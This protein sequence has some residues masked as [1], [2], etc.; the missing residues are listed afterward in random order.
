MCSVSVLQTIRNQFIIL[1]TEIPCRPNC[2]R[3]RSLSTSIS[4][5][6]CNMSTQAL[7]TIPDWEHISGLPADSALEPEGAAAPR[8]SAGPGNEW[9]G[10][11]T[12]SVLAQICVFCSWTLPGYRK[13]HY[14][15]QPLVKRRRMANGWGGVV[16]SVAPS[17]LGSY[18]SIPTHGWGWGLWRWALAHWNTLILCFVNN[19]TCETE[20]TLAWYQWQRA[21]YLRT[22]TPSYFMQLLY[23]LYCLDRVSNIHPIY[24]HVHLVYQ[25]REA[26]Y[27][28]KKLLQC[29]TV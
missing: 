21:L 28:G 16:R 12:L 24:L 18:L 20:T 27:F 23:F 15:Q 11:S 29:V 19:L 9:A 1:K 10:I 7:K 5:Y 6:P 2:C 13:E 22:H 17:L 25:N 3:T 26:N 14:S 4:V 8:A